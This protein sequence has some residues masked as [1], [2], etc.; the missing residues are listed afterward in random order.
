MRGVL[1]LT[2]PALLL[3]RPGGWM[4]TCLQGRETMNDYALLFFQPSEQSIKMLFHSEGDFSDGSLLYFGAIY[5]FLAC[6]TYGIAVP[7]GL[8]IPSL[9]AGAAVGRLYGETQ[10]RDMMMDT[11]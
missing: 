4:L 6:I 5:F 9:L 10:Y 7:S 8:F 1:F 3:L 11:G 2:I